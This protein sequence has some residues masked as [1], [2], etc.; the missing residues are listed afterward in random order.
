M[1]SATSLI[2]E[3]RA[4]GQHPGPISDDNRH[5]WKKKLAE[6]KRVHEEESRLGYQLEVGF[7]SDEDGHNCNKRK[8]ATTDR[9][10]KYGKVAKKVQ[11][12]LDRLSSSNINSPVAKPK[13]QNSES[14]RVCQRPAEQT[15]FRYRLH[16]V[17]VCL[18]A[19]V[20]LGYVAA[21]KVQDTREET[22]L[23]R[24]DNF[25]PCDLEH[26]NETCLSDSTLTVALE[27]S[28]FVAE[29]VSVR[30]GDYDC[31]VGGVRSRNV[32]MKELK[33]QLFVSNKDKE[34]SISALSNALLLFYN[35]PHWGIRLYDSNT[36]IV[37]DPMY[38]DADEVMFLES[39]TPLKSFSCRV[40]NAIR[41]LQ[42]QLLYVLAGIVLG[43]IFGISMWLYQKHLQKQ[44][45]EMFAY[46]EQ[47]LE[48]LE[49]QVGLSQKQSNKKP[50]VVQHHARDKLIAPTQ[51]KAKQRVWKK[52]VAWMAENE[53]RVRVEQLRVAGEYVLVWRW[54]HK[55][56]DDESS[57]DDQSCDKKETSSLR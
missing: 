16:I 52:A 28:Q 26:F 51:R 53:S 24:L 8:V 14:R 48:L 22:A 17:A 10:S 19:G 45:E 55:E 7:S 18:S 13:T 4:Y 9:I 29:F 44:E 36:S 6:L 5:F 1:A 32:S 11:G 40:E 49:K 15:M 34:W 30:S 33:V 47:I 46:V 38:A 39:E 37:S 35:N 20:V 43:I 27:V 41:Q 56:E 42:Y 23:R 54:I 2:Q 25:M 3:L 12:H 31:L 21:S 50:Y 57:T